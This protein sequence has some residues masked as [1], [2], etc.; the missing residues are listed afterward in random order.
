M[1]NRCYVKADS[2]TKS[3]LIGLL[4]LCSAAAALSR[5]AELVPPDVL[6]KSV[7]DDVLAVLRSD[8]EIQAGNVRKVVDLVEKQVLPHFDFVRMT[9]L[10]MGRSWRLAS[11]E[12][13]KLLVREFRSLLVQTYVATFG[14][15]RDQEIEYRPLRAQPGDTEVVVKSQVRQP[16]AQPVTIDY[17]MYRTDAGWKVY[18]VVV[19]DL[20]LVQNYRGSFETEVRRGGI[21][22]LIKALADKNRQ[23]VAQQAS[24]G[25]K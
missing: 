10:A 19:G 5:A 20:S 17:R 8:K 18:D 11:P 23:L 21:D 13:Q 6:A 22:G 16:G 24:A 2:M 12:Q 7:T 4:A 15:Y 9:Q 3:L 1:N 25:R 14:A